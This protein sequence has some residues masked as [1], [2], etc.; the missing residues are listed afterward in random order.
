MALTKKDISDILSDI[1][2]L[3]ELKGDS[4]PFKVRAYQSGARILDTLDD[5]RFEHLFATNSLGSIPGLGEALVTKIIELKTTGKLVFFETLK[6]SIEPG[7]V[8]ML[9]IP[10]LGPKKI[11]AIHEKL[12]VTTIDRL[13]EVCD[14]GLVAELAGFGA[15]SQQ[16]ISEGIKNREAYSKRHLWWDASLIAEPIVKGLRAL[17]GV[18]R[19]EAAGSLRRSLETVG[20][21]DFIAASDEPGPVVAW[22][23]TLPDVKEITA[24]GETKASV[25]FESG[26]QAD[27]RI[28]PDAQFVFALHHFTGSKDHNVQMRQRALARGMSL[29]EWGITAVE[30]EHTQK[31]HK[32]IPS[33]VADEK[34]LF[35]VLDLNYI[36]PELREGLGEIDAAEKGELPELVELSDI[37]GVF[38]NHTTASDGHNSLSEMAK[39]AEALGFEYLGIADHSKASFQANGMYE[40]KLLEQIEAIRNFNKSGVCSCYVFSGSECD[41]LPNGKLDFDNS[42]LAQLDYVVASV[43]SSL[44]QEEEIA[45]KRTIDAIENPYVTMLGHLSGRLLLKRESSKL[46]VSKVIDAAIANN[47]I[48]ELNADPRRLDLDWRFWRKAA[49]KGLKCSINPDAHYTQTLTYV[50]NGI[51]IARKGWLTKHHVINTL[52]LKDV[53]N[54][55]L[56]KKSKG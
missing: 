49:D 41:I 45:T 35:R 24:Q 2:V 32:E 19:A 23:T 1:A 6:A 9:Q 30:S 38:H 5:D 33:Y 34:A 26:L 27:L 55:L 18:K 31:L 52:A 22:F 43:H 25:R 44:T 15:K 3:L 40:D 8:E 46:N 20:D 42:I 13:K 28:V 16:K 11:K 10:G 17:P 54:L 53:K 21:L 37:R 47:V 48:I 29:S 14:Q 39:A 36:P 50:K 56:K 7:L 4:N 12:G 51:G